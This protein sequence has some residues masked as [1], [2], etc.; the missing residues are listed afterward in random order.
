MLR[1]TVKNI[2]TENIVT[3]NKKATVIDAAHVLLRFQINGLLIVE[4]KN[5]TKVVGI[6]TTTDLLRLLNKALSK[7]S[8]KMLE[9]DRI[10]RSPIKSVLSRGVTRIQQNAKL[11]KVVAIMHRKNI[12][13][14]PVYDGKKLVGVVGKHD[15][16]NIAFYPSGGEG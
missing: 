3:L 8:H 16:L 13:T 2:M 15:I 7:H 12:H 5:S 10:A 14:L 11:T 9:L 1:T 6:L 4:K